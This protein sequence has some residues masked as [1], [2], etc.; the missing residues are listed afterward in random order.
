[1]NE[2]MDMN[3]LSKRD[4]QSVEDMKIMECLELEG[5]G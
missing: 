5:Q 1:M 2:S 3:S 4:D